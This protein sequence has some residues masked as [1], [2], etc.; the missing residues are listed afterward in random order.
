MIPSILDRIPDDTVMYLINALAFDAEW[1][2][3]YK[4]NQVYDESFTTAGGDKKE[5]PFMHSEEARYIEDENATGFIKYYKNCQFA[6]AAILPNEDLSPA[7]Y[8]QSLSGEHLYDMIR[9]P[10]V[11]AVITSAPKFKTEYSVEMSEIL[12]AM[13]MSQAFD[14]S[15]ADFGKIGSYNG[16]NLYISRVLHKT[17]IDVDEKGTKAGAATAVEMNGKSAPME[18]V[19]PKTVFRTRPFIYMLIDCGTGIPFFIG[20]MNDPEK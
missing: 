8:L 12:M 17:F 3:P 13:G 14:D 1:E 4:K 6:F 19:E 7:D 11:C 15:E 9:N 18:P 5:V 10:E 16:D 2:E 20:L